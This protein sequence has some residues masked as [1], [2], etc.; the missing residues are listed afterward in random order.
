MFRVASEKSRWGL[1]GRVGEGLVDSL[2]CPHMVWE[3]TCSSVCCRVLVQ[4]GTGSG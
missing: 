3:N 4:G 1:T 2:C